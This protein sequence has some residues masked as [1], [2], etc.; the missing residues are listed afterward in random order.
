MRKSGPGHIEE[1]VDSKKRVVI[2]TWHDNKRVVMLSNYIG[3]DPVDTC[4]WVDRKAG[5]KTDVE[6]TASIKVYNTFMGG[7]DKA[8]MLLSLYRT[9]YR[10]RKWY[11]RVAFHLFSQAVY[12]PWMDYEKLSGDKIW[13]I[14]QQKCASRKCMGPV[15][16]LI[17][18][19]MFAQKFIVQ[20]RA[21]IFQEKCVMTNSITSPFLSI[22]PNSQRCKYELCNKKNEISIHK[23]SGLSLCC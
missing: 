18:S 8:D 20:W 16:L 14:L 21:Q 13:L 15:V 17:Q 19:M 10:S 23:M 12:N 11:Y 22:P 1:I 3:K 2:T 4:K 9:K 7:A 5:Q 6:R